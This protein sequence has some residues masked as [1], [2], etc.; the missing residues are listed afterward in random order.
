M[1]ARPRLGFIGLGAMGRPMAL[2][3]INAGY[4][5]SVYARRPETA[6]PLVAAGARA[7]PTPAALAAECDVVFTIVTASADSEQVALGP[8]GIIEG[9][10]KGTVVV[11]MA[12]ISPLATRRIAQALE[13]RDVEHLDAPVS[14]GPMGAQGATLAI[15]AGGKPLVFERIKPLFERLGKTL[16]HMGD[17]GAGQV[18]KACNQLAL[19]VTAQGAAEALALARRCGLD[20]ARVHE[21]LMGGFAASRVLELFGRRMAGRNFGP[22][23]D[24]RFYHKDVAIALELA[25]D[26]GLPLPAAAA[27]KQ[28]INAL[29]GAGDGGADFS[30]LI[31]V[32]ERASGDAA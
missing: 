6:A 29:M 23:I 10:R 3:L 18:T 21:V 1:T 7:F 9:A 24:A 11:D 17:H 14:G 19:T 13:A 28:Q 31:R 8:Q 12:T 2:N 27:V 5:M 30:V 4:P 22:G 26:A 20:P 32:L 15:M 16:L 25:Q